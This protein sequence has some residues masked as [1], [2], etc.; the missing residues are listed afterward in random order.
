MYLQLAEDQIDPREF[1]IP[2]YNRKTGEITHVRED[3]LDNLPENVYNRVM[4]EAEYMEANGMA[5]GLADKAARQARRNERKAAKT[6]KKQA[7]NAI[8]FAKADK[9]KG[10]DDSA[11]Q[12]GAAAPGSEPEPKKTVFGSILDTVG[13]IFGGKAAGQAAV[14]TGATDTGKKDNTIWYV[15]GGVAVLGTAAL[16]Y[17]ESHKS[18]KRGRRR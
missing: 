2:C 16:I 13:S 17:S 3:L 15:I 4:E 10:G 7:K 1:Y 8:K 11:K 14:Q 18:K 6:E 12:E 9:M 5:E